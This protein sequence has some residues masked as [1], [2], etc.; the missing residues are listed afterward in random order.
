MQP[1]PS[2]QQHP[3][4][5]DRLVAR[6]FWRS[7]VAIALVAAAVVAV[8]LLRP[9]PVAPTGSDAPAEPPAPSAAATTGPVAGVA[10]R[11]V[12]AASGVDFVH[13]SGARGAKF[14]PECLAGGVAMVDLDLDGRLDLVFSQGQPLEP[15][16]GDPAAGRGGVRIYLNRTAPAGALR[17]ERLAGDASL[18]ADS[19][20]NG[21]A[22]GDL[23]CDGRADLYIACVGQ[24]RLLMNRA[25]AGGT[26]E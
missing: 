9:V 7:I 17:F 2:D 23:D 5:D 20:A 21:I 12:A 19:Y 4:L 18:A 16:E 14:L 15:V 1:A 25:G 3:E 24:D 6:G 22:A 11:D 10:F 26:L 8:V 13:E